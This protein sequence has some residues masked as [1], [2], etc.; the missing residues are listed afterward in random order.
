MAGVDVN[1]GKLSSD[2]DVWELIPLLGCSI[3]LIE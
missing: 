2:L 3:A 1:A